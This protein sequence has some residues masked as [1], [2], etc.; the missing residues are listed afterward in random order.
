MSEINNK[1]LTLQMLEA[2][3]G[4]LRISDLWYPLSEFSEEHAEEAK[5]LC[6]MKQQFENVV[7]NADLPICENCGG[8]MRPNIPRMGWNGGAVHIA[9][10][11][12]NC[13]SKTL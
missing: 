9:N 13:P 10:N 2:I 8:E 3:Q 5:A 12:F 6:V 11:G 1:E 4:A 7:K